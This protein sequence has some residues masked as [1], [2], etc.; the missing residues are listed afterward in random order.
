LLNNW[1][2]SLQIDEKNGTILSSMVGAG[3][4]TPNNTFEGVLMGDIQKADDDD[5]DFDYYNKQ[6]LGLYGFND[7]A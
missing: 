7:G 1:D 3:R 6:G 5:E 4:K 2:G